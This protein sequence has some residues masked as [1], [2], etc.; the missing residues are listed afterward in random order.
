MFVA[1][2]SARSLIY[3][4]F[5]C[6]SRGWRQ[7][8]S[9]NRTRSRATPS[10]TSRLLS[11][12]TTSPAHRWH[13]CCGE[14][15]LDRQKRQR[16]LPCLRARPP[17]AV[18]NER[19]SLKVQNRCSCQHLPPG[20]AATWQAADQHS[21]LRR[22]VALQRRRQAAALAHVVH[23][24]VL[25]NPQAKLKAAE[26]PPSNVICVQQKGDRH[27]MWV[28]RSRNWQG[29]RRTES[30]RVHSLGRARSSR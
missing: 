29:R 4:G 6:Y 28:R 3:S 21:R 5:C 2:P 22:G 7:K 27:R 14:D 20:A 9:Q 8:K 11:D 18:L 15:S 10:M 12:A 24:C 23:D 17:A 19:G 13:Q 16:L 30:S 1:A 25:Q 26:D